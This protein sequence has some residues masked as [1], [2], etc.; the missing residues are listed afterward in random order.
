MTIDSYRLIIKK[1]R[2]GKYVPKLTYNGRDANFSPKDA[3]MEELIA[4]LE[5]NNLPAVKS[6]KLEIIISGEDLK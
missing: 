2:D 1:T 3:F 4:V 5:N 6:N